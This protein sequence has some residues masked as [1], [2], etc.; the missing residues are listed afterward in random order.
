M[1]VFYK[2]D[3]TYTNISHEISHLALYDLRIDEDNVDITSMRDDELLAHR[4]SYYTGQI[5]SILLKNGYTIQTDEYWG[6]IR[7]TLHD[8]ELQEK[9]VDLAMDKTI[10]NIKDK[11]KA[12][13]IRFFI[14]LFLY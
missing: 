4:V 7:Q 2:N 8:Y 5:M 1:V 10:F 11:I 9:K 6:S 14:S 3:I 13:K 12:D